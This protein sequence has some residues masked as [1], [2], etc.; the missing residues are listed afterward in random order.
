MWPFIL[1]T[2]GLIFLCYYVVLF[3]W[4]KLFQKTYRSFM[5]CCM[6][7]REPDWFSQGCGQTTHVY[8][9]EPGSRTL[10]QSSQDQHYRWRETCWIPLDVQTKPCGNTC[11][12]ETAEQ[13]AQ[14][15]SWSVSGPDGHRGWTKPPLVYWSVKKMLIRGITDIVSVVLRFRCV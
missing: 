12:L 5:T 8:V 13:K 1:L 10:L 7:R 15:S 11:K 6:S 9:G 2:Y 14:V 4:T 3:L